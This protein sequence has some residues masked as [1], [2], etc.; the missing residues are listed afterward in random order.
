VSIPLLVPSTTFDTYDICQKCPIHHWSNWLLPELSDVSELLGSD[1]S[2]G[3]P[4]ASTR[5]LLL[6]L[7][8]PPRFR[9]EFLEVVGIPEFL[10]LSDDLSLS[11][12]PDCPP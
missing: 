1:P 5:L 7:L 9:Y 10:P 3:L 2:R 11:Q 4:L 8:L 12:L 6:L